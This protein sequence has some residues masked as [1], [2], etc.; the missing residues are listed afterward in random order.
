MS[1]FSKTDAKAGACIY[2]LHGLLQRLE[3]TQPGLVEELLNGAKADQNACN[4]QVSPSAAASQI[5]VEAI[6][7]LELIHAQNTPA[8]DSGS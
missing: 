6:A 8:F 5:L 3:A 2:I 1:G 7:V 4:L